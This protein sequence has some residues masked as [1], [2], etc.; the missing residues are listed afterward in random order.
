MLKL[1]IGGAWEP[2]DFIEVLQSVESLYYKAAHYQGIY[3]SRPSWIW[4]EFYLLDSTRDMYPSFEEALSRMNRRLL[5]Q[6]RYSASPALRLKV[7]RIRYASP[8]GI[9][10][11]GVGKA[12]EAIERII[13]KIIAYFDE[14]GLRRE[15]DKQAK[16]DTK[17]KEIGAE[18]EHESLRS[19]QIVYAREILQLRRDFPDA[20]PILLPLIVRDQEMLTDRITQRKLIGASVSSGPDK[21]TG[22][23][24]IGDL[25]EPR[26][27][28]PDLI[29]S[30]RAGGG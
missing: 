15:R 17:I 19:L 25:Q 7:A 4:G 28:W 26:L 29:P 10:L 12:C 20:E 6:A 13:S 11:I 5:D 9:D 22:Q 16:L 18:K 14:R 24:E 30:L 21:T 2:E 1:K 23:H 3:I 27:S 8:G